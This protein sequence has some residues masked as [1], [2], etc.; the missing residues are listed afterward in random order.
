MSMP[1]L[2]F[3]RPSGAGIVLLLAAGPL[4][5]QQSAIVE[6]LAPLL[7]AEDA[8]NFLPELYHKAL[9]SPDSVVRRVAAIGAGRIGDPAA[10]PLLV[11][12]LL[13]SG[14]HGTGRG[15]LRPGI[16]G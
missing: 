12:I 6:Q 14:L 16:A 15:G 7:A 10:V 4:A 13:G 2:R 11:P 8:R 5:A 1:S 9:V 3:L